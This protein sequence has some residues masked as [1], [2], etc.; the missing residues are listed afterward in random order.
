VKRIG[1][2]PRVQV[3]TFGTAVVSQ[4][5]GLGLVEAARASG[6]G[7]CAVDGAVALA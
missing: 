1:L 7:S 5:G 3:D 4:S 6:L 2:Y